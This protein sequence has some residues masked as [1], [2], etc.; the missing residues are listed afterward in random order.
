M[1][2]CHSIFC[3]LLV[4]LACLLAAVLAACRAGAATANGAGGVAPVGGGG[5]TGPMPTPAPRAPVP[6]QGGRAGGRKAQALASE[7]VVIDTL[8]LTHWL[9]RRTPLKRVGMCDIIAAI[10][11]TAPIIRRRFPGRIIFVTKDREAQASKEDAARLR[12][13][14]QTAARRCGVYVDVVER[15]PGEKPTGGTK[16]QRPHSSLGRDDFYLIM[17]AWRY[18]C[19]VLSQ[20]HFNDL[21]SMKSGDLAP[22]HVYS[23]SPVKAY[24]ER[25]FVNP[26]AAE[27]RRLRRP[28][29]IDFGEVLPHN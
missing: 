5:D 14:Y 9:R 22:F 24:P 6:W 17:L 20:D 11:E 29:G 12:A 2:L 15:L 8:N 13:Q 18:G 25:D 21:D 4:V 28:A 27:F 19:P 1:L 23:Y 3:I 26:A 7:N 16:P 10:E